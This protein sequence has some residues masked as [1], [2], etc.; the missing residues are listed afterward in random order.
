MTNYPKAT[1]VDTNK[2]QPRE[3]IHMEFD[4]YNVTSIHVL[5]SM[6][7]VVCTNTRMIWIFPTASKRYPVHIVRFILTTL[8]NEQHICKFVRVDEYGAL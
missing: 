6:L 5:I 3:L 2:I 1:T 4:L 8:D 7:N